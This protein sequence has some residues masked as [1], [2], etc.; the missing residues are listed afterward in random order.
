M[1]TNRC[2]AFGI[3]LRDFQMVRKDFHQCV[4]AQGLFREAH[5][6][7]SVCGGEIRGNVGTD[8]GDGELAGAGSGI[9]GPVGA[10]N[11]DR[12]VSGVVLVQVDPGHPTSCSGTDGHGGSQQPVWHRC[13]S[14]NGRRLYVALAGENAVARG[15][16][17]FVRS[18]VLLD[19]G[20]PDGDVL[21][22]PGYSP[23]K[24]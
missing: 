24:S 23:S 10:R 12:A 13:C 11:G 15:N 6:Q 17:E 3:R 8:V 4:A 7:T 18:D 19:V 21:G 5:G 1:S 2:S 16:E 14:P 20:D 22:E 9:P